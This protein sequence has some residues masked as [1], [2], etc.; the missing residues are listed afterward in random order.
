MNSQTTEPSGKGSSG[1]IYTMCC[2]A[3]WNDDFCFFL[4]FTLHNICSQK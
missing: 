1:P 4:T 3:I 2:G